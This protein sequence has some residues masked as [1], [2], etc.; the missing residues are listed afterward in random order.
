MF[1][2]PTSV[3]PSFIVAVRTR[4]GFEQQGKRRQTMTRRAPLHRSPILRCE[5][6]I[7]GSHRQLRNIEFRS[8]SLPG[9]AQALA[10]I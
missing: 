8:S 4:T 2:P 5:V 1:E 7:V 3:I 10:P 6:R 9:M